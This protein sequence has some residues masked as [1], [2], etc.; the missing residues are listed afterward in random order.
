MQGFLIVPAS[1]DSGV[2]AEG[3]VYRGD[4]SSIFGEPGVTGLNTDDV[5]TDTSGEIIL[6]FG[7]DDVFDGDQRFSDIFGGAGDDTLVVSGDRFVADFSGGAGLDTIDLRGASVSAA[8]DYNFELT[9]D[10]ISPD[11]LIFTAGAASRIAQSV[12]RV[13]GGDGTERLI[14]GTNGIQISGGGGND[15]LGGGA[16]EIFGNGG[17]DVLTGRPGNDTLKGGGGR[18]VFQFRASDRNDMIVDFRQ[19]QDVIEI[20]SGAR[21]FAAGTC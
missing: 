14:A 5:F 2:A 15:F 6:G 11:R 13:C 3:F 12:E 4:P 8:D 17:A 18:D 16:D 19:G 9:P 10:P 21:A 20:V 7:G 1:G